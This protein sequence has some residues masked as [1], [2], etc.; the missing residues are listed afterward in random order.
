MNTRAPSQ[1]G[2][3]T[4]S[5]GARTLCHKYS[6]VIIVSRQ[7]DPQCRVKVVRDAAQQNMKMSEWRW[8]RILK[9]WSFGSK[10][11]DNINNKVFEICKSGRSCFNWTELGVMLSW[12]DA[13]IC[14]S[15]DTQ[16]RN[17]M[18]KNILFL[19]LIKARD[20]VSC[21]EIIWDGASE[22]SVFNVWPFCL[23]IV[24]F[25]N[26]NTTRKQ[27]MRGEMLTLWP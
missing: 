21:I 3:L 17:G 12:K 10:S 2:I 15:F 23:I 14:H 19:S 1:E 9:T 16:Y 11:V 13:E 5:P 20:N 6:R 25:R 22:S 7:K 8:G 18:W 4:Q 27:R 26:W 24:L